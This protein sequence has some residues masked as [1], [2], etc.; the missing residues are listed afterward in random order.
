MVGEDKDFTAAII[1]LSLSSLHIPQVDR[2]GSRL[3]K[4]VKPSPPKSGMHAALIIEGVG[5]ISSTVAVTENPPVL[6]WAKK[7]DTF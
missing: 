1:F 7:E 6:H 2:A 5:L 3:L 4:R